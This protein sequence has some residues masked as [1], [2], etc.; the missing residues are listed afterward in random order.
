MKEEPMLAKDVQVGDQMGAET[1]TGVVEV[2]ERTSSARSPRPPSPPDPHP[3]P[4]RP[5]GH[6]RRG[7]RLC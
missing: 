5:V 2:Q 1:V 4:P 3:A 7:G 6:R